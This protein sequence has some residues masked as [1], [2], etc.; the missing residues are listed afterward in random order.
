MAEVIQGSEEFTEQ[1]AERR[2][3]DGET[4]LVRTWLGPQAGL[5]AKLIE[6]NNMSPT[7]ES[8]KSFNG[9]PA[10]VQATFP[11]QEDDEDDPAARA[12][13][14]AVWE[15]IPQQINKPLA[16]HGYF[17]VSGS[18]LEMLEAADEAIRK[19]TARKTNWDAAPYV[20]YHIQSY[21]N[22]RLR[23]IDTYV[24][25]TY[26]VRRTVVFN[27]ATF[28]QAEFSTAPE[29]HK[30]PGVITTWERIG[31]P[32]SA[33]FTK[34]K[35]HSAKHNVFGDGQWEDLE[36]D[37]WLVMAPSVK[38]Q[39]GKKRWELVREWWGAE[40]WSSALYQYGTYVP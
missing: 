15:L 20:G 6:V 23:G 26:I 5:S 18:A 4:K 13:A 1:P 8:T 39:R 37:E 17:N 33:K 35:I 25:F 7:P 24:A 9:V 29:A 27:S 34:P 14:A 2:T 16:T 12:E 22:H 40:K 11:D 3:D 10:M 28:L 31:V 19:G 32:D 38:W 30:L 36:L 21:V